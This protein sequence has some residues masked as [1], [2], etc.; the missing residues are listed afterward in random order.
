M[1]NFWCPDHHNS[2]FFSQNPCDRNILEEL[3]SGQLGSTPP[4]PAEATPTKQET[5]PTPDDEEGEDFD[6]NIDED[7]DLDD[8]DLNADV[9]FVSQFMYNQ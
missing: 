8:L 2:P 3:R 7:L 4:L 9:S 6:L 5:T 1:D